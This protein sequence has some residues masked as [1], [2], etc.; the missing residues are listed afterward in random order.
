MNNS[1]NNKENKSLNITNVNKNVWA[2]PYIDQPIDFWNQLHQELGEHIQEVYFPLPQGVIGSGRPIQ[3]KK[4]L[5]TFLLNSPLRKSLL[6][7]PIILP[8]PVED[9]SPSIIDAISPL[10]S[11]FGIQSITV[12]NLLLGEKIKEQFPDLSLT[13]SVLLDITQQNQLL[14]LNGVFDKIVPGSRVMRNVSALKNL[15]QAFEG[16]IRLIVNE[17]CLSGCPFRIQHFY[18]MGSDLPFP[19]SLCNHL[20]K[21]KPWLRLTGAWVLPQ[22]LHLYEDAFDEL[23]LAG[24]V[25]LRNP[26]YYILILKSYINRDTLFPNQIGGGPASVM[27]SIEI[28]E[29]FYKKTLRCQHSHHK[30]TI[31]KDYFNEG[32]NKANPETEALHFNPKHGMLNNQPI[33]RDIKHKETI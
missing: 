30:C 26:A 32:V 21:E 3:P 19:H 23:K 16:K 5:N 18:E 28:T 11:E 25:S 31:C 4:Y 13:A 29:E 10:V 1:D 20:L 6:I 9:I 14:M 22:H 24:R 8:Q 17:G 33:Y 7:N 12:S 2:I 15:R 27:H